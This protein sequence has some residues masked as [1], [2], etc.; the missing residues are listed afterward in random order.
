MLLNQCHCIY[1]GIKLLSSDDQKRIPWF[2]SKYKNTTRYKINH[3]YRFGNLNWY[4]LYTQYKEAC[5][6]HGERNLGNLDP[7]PPMWTLLLNSCY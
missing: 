3:M 5:R 7:P 4:L 2:T 6:N 1:T